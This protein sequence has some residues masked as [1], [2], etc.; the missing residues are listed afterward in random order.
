MTKPKQLHDQMWFPLGWMELFLN[1]KHVQSGDSLV[2]WGDSQLESSTWCSKRFKIHPGTPCKMAHLGNFLIFQCVTTLSEDVINN[3]D[4]CVI[5]T[6]AQ[7]GAGHSLEGW[8]LTEGSS[9]QRGRV[10]AAASSALPAPPAPGV[11]LRPLSPRRPTSAHW[12]RHRGQSE[13]VWQLIPGSTITI[14]RT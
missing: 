7:C 2:L 9:V 13:W 1:W 14:L 11:T 4:E 3:T 8:A 10:G 6:W 12:Q 5:F